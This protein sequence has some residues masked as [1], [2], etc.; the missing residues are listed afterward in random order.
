MANV[1]VTLDYPIIDGQAL[2]FK[3]P[4]ACTEVEGLIIYYP[5]EKGA[6]TL[7]SKVFKF[8]DAQHNELTDLGNLFDKDAYVNVLLDTGNNAAYIQN[9]NTNAYI[10]GE[11]AKKAPMYT[12]GTTDIGS[13]VE[14]EGEEGSLYFVIE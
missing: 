5:E 1:K 12:Y 11:L 9:A 8:K 2:T 3:A 13:G 10:E 4:C 6:E 7:V 14:M